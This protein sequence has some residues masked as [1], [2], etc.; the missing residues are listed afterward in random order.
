MIA[1]G[2]WPM[3]TPAM[4]RCLFAAFFASAFQQAWSKA[5][6]NVVAITIVGINR[7]F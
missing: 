3:I 7:S 1:Y 6:H 2:K 4:L 5:A